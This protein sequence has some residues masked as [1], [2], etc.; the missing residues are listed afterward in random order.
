[1]VLN[2]CKFAMIAA[3]AVLCA[4]AQVPVIPDAPTPAAPKPVPGTLAEPG[5]LAKDRVAPGTLATKDKGAPPST[6]DPDADAVTPAGEP[7][8]SSKIINIMAPVTVFDQNG[9]I[10]NNIQPSWFHLFDNGVEQDIHVDDEVQPISLVIAIEGSYR[11][12][13]IL[14]QIHKIGPL[15]E[16]LI[17]G[18][19]G[20]AAVI[21]FDH[22]IQTLQDFTSD[23]DKIK[24]AVAKVSSGST[25]AKMVDAVDAAILMLRHR[26]RDRR[27]IILLISEQRDK[28]SVARGRE[29]LIALQLAN[30]SLYAVDINQLSRRLTEQPEPPRPDPLPPAAYNFPMGANTPTQVD[31][32]T[33]RGNNLEFLPGLMEIYTDAKGIFKRNPIEVFTQGTGGRKFSFIKERGLEDAVAAIGNE[34]H[35]QYILSYNPKPDTALQGGF[36]QL[37]VT[38]DYPRAKARTRPG[39]WLAPVTN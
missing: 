1:M 24:V 38:V 16:P 2:S 18:G 12:D 36:H 22:R 31:Q 33:G 21:E 11:D 32:V 3:V 13:A 8:F 29:T 27:R 23:P 10:M 20:E 7:R 39:Y 25:S 5:T 28:G 17:T 35:S 30:V 14:K 26:P 37:Q 34:I 15:I 9:Q 4:L 6:P 19:N